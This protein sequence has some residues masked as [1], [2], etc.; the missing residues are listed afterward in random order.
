VPLSPAVGK[1]L[2]EPWLGDLDGMQRRRVVR[3]A[4]VFNRT[5]YFVDRGV[6]RG[7]FY[8]ALKLFEDELNAGR[9]P[10]ERV[11]V[12]FVPLSREA[13]VP[14]LVNGQV[15]LVAAAMTITPER[16][17]LIDFSSPTRTGVNEIVVTA[18]DLPP[19]ASAEDLAGQ[20]VFVRKSSSYYTSL[21]TLNER[22]GRLEKPAVRLE[23]APENLEDDDL[24]EMVNAGLVRAVVVDD[25]LA[26]FWAQV[27]PNLQ[28]HPAAAVA[29]GG[30]IAVAL[31]KNSPQLRAALAAW[32]AAH[33]P[34][35]L[36]GNLVTQRY[37]KST[38]FVTSATAN[39]QRRRF[40]TLVELFRKYSDK[41][42]VDYLLMIA[43]AYQESGLDHNVKSSAGAVGVMQLLPS[44][45]DDMKVGNIQKL[46]PNIHAGV[47][48]IRLMMDEYFDEPGLTPLNRGL[49]AFAAYNAGP[50][51]I[52]ELR[53]KAAER[54]LDP[55][56][57]FNNVER[58]ASEEIG[59]ET[60]QYVSNIFKYYVAYRL[61]E[62][63][64]GRA[65]TAA[66]GAWP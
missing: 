62:A 15:D 40:E 12:V 52:R 19:L 34:R 29:T 9:R 44:T 61:A 51:R 45:G 23:P 47:K 2:F 14:A 48:Y 3:A 27:L 64:D 16:E 28:L 59:R 10:D 6:Q 20:T 43:Q 53:R 21:L 57:W 35:T 37:L 66:K 42:G 26:E 60:V 41:Y 46:E 8:E 7:I 1:R 63:A 33:G 11:H 39:E 5:H 65:T 54:Q 30:R 4:V 13:L 32:I 31:R 24:L 25:Y 55:D 22:L 56:V 58:V 17:R 49:F 18:R 38:A 36:F 50:A